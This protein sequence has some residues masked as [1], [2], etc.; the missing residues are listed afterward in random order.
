MEIVRLPQFR[1]DIQIPGLTPAMGKC[2]QAGN[3]GELIFWLSGMVDFFFLR[4]RLWSEPEAKISAEEVPL[5]ME[6]F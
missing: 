3:C 1:G 4:S 5:A 2:G 6:W